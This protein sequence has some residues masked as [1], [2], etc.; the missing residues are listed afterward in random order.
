T[1]HQKVLMLVKNL[2]KQCNSH[3]P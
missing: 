1:E 3:G 2:D